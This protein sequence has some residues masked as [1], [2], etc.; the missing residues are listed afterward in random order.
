MSQVPAEDPDRQ[1]L[2]DLGLTDQ[3]IDEINASEK[4]EEERE[5]ESRM[6]EV[7]RRWAAL[8]GTPEYAERRTASLWVRNIFEVTHGRLRRQL[9]ADQLGVSYL[10]VQLLIQ[11]V[12]SR[13]EWPIDRIEHLLDLY[14]LE[15]LD[16]YRLRLAFLIMVGWAS[17]MERDIVLGLMRSDL[18]MLPSPPEE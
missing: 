13:E 1:A 10:L 11:G 5:F 4:T 9:I 18:D 8:M 6:T 17:Q 16:R 12:A 2:R 14:P 3:E 7:V 15:S